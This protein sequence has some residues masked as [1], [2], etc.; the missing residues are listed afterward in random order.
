MRFKT[1]GFSLIEIVVVV[2][3]IGILSAVALPAYNAYRLRAIIGAELLPVLRRAGND[4]IEYYFTMGTVSGYCASFSDSGMITEY[5]TRVR[6]NPATTTQPIRFVARLDIDRFGSDIP[7]AAKLIFFP[8]EST[9][10]VR[11]HCAYHLST[12]HR[13]PGEYLPTTC[14]NNY[15]ASNWN[16]YV[17]GT[18]VTNGITAD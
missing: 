7:S 11:W 18:L 8:T 12:V 4:L 6:C 13:I 2:A 17:D 16:L 1:Q 15:V 5:V 10:S 9:G 14:R 3:I